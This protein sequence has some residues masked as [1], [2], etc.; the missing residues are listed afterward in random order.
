MR[1][2][3]NSSITAFAEE[4][5]FITPLTLLICPR[6]FYKYQ[7]TNSAVTYI[8]FYLV[9]MRIVEVNEPHPQPNSSL[10]DYN[11]LNDWPHPLH[12]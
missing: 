7:Q 6:S 9:N 5:F 4:L 3:N 10:S 2:I 8:N 12:P 11:L 1:N